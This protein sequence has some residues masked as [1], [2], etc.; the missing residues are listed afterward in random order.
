MLAKL[1]DFMARELDGEERALLAALLTPGIARAYEEHE[2]EGF[3]LVDWLPDALPASLEEAL[4]RGG[5]RVTG[6]ADADGATDA[7]PEAG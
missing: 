5:V 1:R 2:V 7:G 4:R 6:L 3:G